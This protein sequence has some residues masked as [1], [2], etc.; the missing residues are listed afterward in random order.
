[1]TRCVLMCEILLRHKSK[2]FLIDEFRTSKFCLACHFKM[3]KHHW[4][5]NP[6]KVSK[7]NCKPKPK[8]TDSDTATDALL[9]ASSLSANIIEAYGPKCG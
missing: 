5:P 2:V 7:S 9:P 4:V 6:H 3:E 8:Q 1:M